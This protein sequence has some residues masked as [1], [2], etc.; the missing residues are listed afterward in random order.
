MLL[1]RVKHSNSEKYPNQYIFYVKIDNY[2]YSVSFVEDK[3][4]IFL[5]TIYPDRIA[6]KIYLG[7]NND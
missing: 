6:T 4:K 7:D 5:K 1:D 3:N 2:V